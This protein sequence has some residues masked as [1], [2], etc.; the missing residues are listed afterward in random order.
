MQT[1]RKFLKIVSILVIQLLVIDFNYLVEADDL[2]ESDK[3]QRFEAMSELDEAFLLSENG[4]VGRTVE[5][6]NNSKVNYTVIGDNIFSDSEVETLVNLIESQ[7]FESSVWIQDLDTD[8]VFVY[9]PTERYY[10]AQIIKSPYSIWICRNADKGLIDLQNPIENHYDLCSDSKWIANYKDDE[11]IDPW[12]CIDAMIYAS[13]NKATSILQRT[14]PVTYRKSDD[15]FNKFL[16]N[17]LEWEE[18]SCGEVDRD[19]TNGWLTVTDAAKTLTYLY[20]YF[21]SNS[22]NGQRLKDSYTQ[23]VHNYL[24]FPEDIEVAK[25]YGSWTDAFHDIAIVYADHPYL[26]A[27]MT[28][29]GEI[30]HFRT[31]AVNYMQELG[32]LAYDYTQN[33]RNTVD[34]T[35]YSLIKRCKDIY[36]YMWSI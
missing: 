28:D 8:D 22:L 31:D 25:K 20:N 12:V 29:A 2:K 14:W 9:N 5:G 7:D 23:A 32:K 17:I 6:C 21:E 3:S 35:C 34:Y 26:I 1:L 27:C 19:T 4:L 13:D 36:N 16:H 10:Q 18:N 33:D 24:W 11:T 15:D 30:A